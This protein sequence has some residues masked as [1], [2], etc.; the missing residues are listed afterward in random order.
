MD[1]WIGEATIAEL[2]WHNYTDRIPIETMV[3]STNGKES[4]ASAL[5]SP[6][7][8]LVHYQWPSL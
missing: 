3:E 2:P 8:M 6:A 1:R 4:G 5:M 7:K